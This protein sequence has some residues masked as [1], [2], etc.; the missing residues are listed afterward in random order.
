MVSNYTIERS[1]NPFDLR[2]YRLVPYSTHFNDIDLLNKTLSELGEK[3]QLST[4]NFSNPVIDFLQTED[5]VESSSVNNKSHN[6]TEISPAKEE[7]IEEKGLWDFITDG[8]ASMKRIGEILSEITNSTVAVGKRMTKRTND[9]SKISRSNKLGSSSK[10]YHII[11]LVATE[12]LVYGEQV[13]G[14]LPELHSSWETFSESTTDMLRT[15]TLETPEDK[16]AT[17]TY[18][19]QIAELSKATSGGLNGTKR[20]ICLVRER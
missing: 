18:K 13:D 12:I 16:E 17:E 7:I 5:I 11:E 20:F 4:E 1:P 15:I 8:E 6:Q 14:Y 2:S 10:K 19:L 3:V 9:F